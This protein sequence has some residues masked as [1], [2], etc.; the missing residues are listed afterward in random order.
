LEENE[1]IRLHKWYDTLQEPRRFLTFF[2]PMAAITVLGA[3]VY[4]VFYILILPPLVS[5]ARYLKYL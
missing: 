5:R 2:I 4:P 1:M 3:L